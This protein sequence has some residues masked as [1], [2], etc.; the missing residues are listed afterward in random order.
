MQQTTKRN[1]LCWT[2]AHRYVTTTNSSQRLLS[3]SKWNSD[4]R[5]IWASS[6]SLKQLTLYLQVFNFLG[7][8]LEMIS[9]VVSHHPQRQCR[10]SVCTLEQVPIHSLLVNQQQVSCTKSCKNMTFL[11]QRSK[12]YHIYCKQ[13]K[14]MGLNGICLSNKS[15]KVS[16]LSLFSFE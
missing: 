14:M 6:S 12:Q 15:T 9:Y 7:S 1:L 8:S 16:T 11:P 5:H 3:F 4:N 2:A 10:L 13:N